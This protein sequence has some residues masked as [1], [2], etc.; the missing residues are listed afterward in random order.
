MFYITSNEVPKSYYETVCEITTAGKPKS[1][2]MKHVNA[3]L[4]KDLLVKASYN[5]YQTGV[6]VKTQKIL[7]FNFW[8]IITE[9]HCEEVNFTVE[10]IDPS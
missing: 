8:K 7:P 3:F 1:L 2:L 4:N 6:R 9:Y 10:S 5:D